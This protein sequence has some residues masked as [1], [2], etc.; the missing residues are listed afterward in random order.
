[1]RRHI[2]SIAIVASIL[3]V[4]LSLSA[5]GSKVSLLST[6]ACNENGVVDKASSDAFTV[7]IGFK[8][9]GK[10]VGMW[11]VNIAF[12]GENWTWIG[13]SQ[14]LTLQSDSTRTL[15]WFGTVPENASIDSVARLIV[16]Y[17]DTIVALNWWIHVVPKAQLAITS[18]TVT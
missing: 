17:D 10:T 3:I 4:I 11:S 14:N 18:S 15:T 2:S 13:A 7:E 5:T 9:I 8:N 16:Y 12:E 6:V 1:M